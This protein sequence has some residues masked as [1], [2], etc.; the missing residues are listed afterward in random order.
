MERYICIHGHFYQPPRE[1]PWLEAIERQDSAYPYHD[2]NE[3]I[4]AECYRPN[5]RARILDE[6]DRIIDIGN[7]YS[8]ISFNFGPTLLSWLEEQA[9]DVYRAVREADAES[10]ER[11]S[12]HGSALAQA[13][14]HVILPLANRRDKE[15]QVRWG[16]RDFERRFGRRPEGLWLPETAVDTETLEV[17]AAE[18]LAFTVLAP[19][20][21]S[22]VRPIGGRAWKDVS[23]GRIDPS[24][25]YEA[26]LPSGRRI[27]LF[28]YDGPI[29]R[30]VA[31]EGLLGKGEYLAGRLAGAFSDERDWAQLVHIATDG[32][33]YGHHHRQGEMAL[34]Y[35]LRHIEAAG[36]ARLTNYGEYLERHP[37]THEVEIFEQ[38][39]WS[40]VHGVGRWWTDC[41]CNSG[42]HP[43]WNQAWRTPVRNALDWLRDELGPRFE[44][45]A[46]ELLKEPW[47]A[48]DAYVDVILDRA[49][50]SRARFLEEHRAR[51][52]SEAEQVRVLQLLELQRHAQ[53]MYTSCGWFFDELTG[54]E[55]VQVIQYA[56][57]ALHLAR[58]LFDDGME[59]GFLD[60]LAAARSNLP[61]HGDGARLYEQW[62]K[63]TVVD[64]AKV[65][66][67]YAISSL[68]E[69]Y[70][71]HM[72][73]YSYAVEREDQRIAQAGRAR[74][75]LGRAWFLS[76]I[77]Q[78][79]QYLTYGVLHYGDHTVVAGVREHR[80]EEAYEEMARDATAA[81]E[82][83]DF[84][85]AVRVMDRHFGSSN[86]SLKTLFRDEQR[87]LLGLILESTLEET[88]AV[89]RQIYENHAPLMRFIGDLGVP[90]PR[91]LRTTAEYVLNGSLRRLLREEDPD[92]ERARALLD[93]ARREGVPLDGQGLSFELGRTLERL[94]ERV[95]AAPEDLQPLT[96]VASLVGL[97]AAPPF[98][99]NLSRVQDLYW[100]LLQEEY[101][102]RKGAADE[103]S[104]SWAASFAALGSELGVRVDPEEG[105]DPAPSPAPS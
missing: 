45:A 97:A 18:G 92:A 15:T 8:R 31:F 36:L 51:E 94:M 20:Q 14:N 54:I 30:A 55:T 1:N 52:L 60:R 34:A 2:W 64:L 6:K 19:S 22:R 17:L 7:N 82:R 41:G 16:I 24:R 48:R 63:P 96:L 53:L 44:S 74:L 67:H 4:T 93:A 102:R 85:E 28:F 9:G 43:G 95:H 80:G 62:V 81:F 83:A 50:E 65:G 70:P 91:V 26:R 40:C 101:P 10:R 5:A 38:T 46:G 100:E 75:L 98:E 21:A 69:G 71:E 39:A 56:G 13:Y 103:E 88:A 57:A 58:E 3:R 12:G 78:E 90:L 61:G 87:K 86:Y 104:R 23:G 33:T 11:F 27:A 47:R 37:P 77:T 73:L 42:S 79:R 35:A 25:A 29:S 76:Q 89:Y 32:E 68:F 105:A 84:P 59:R 49:A 72:R 66:A 99:V